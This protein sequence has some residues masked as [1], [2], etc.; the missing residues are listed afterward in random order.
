[1]AKAIGTFL[2]ALSAIWIVFAVLRILAGLAG[3]TRGTDIALGF[4]G[5]LIAVATF[6]LGTWLKSRQPGPPVTQRVQSAKSAWWRADY[7]FRLS[8]FLGVVWAVGCYLW[9]DDYDRNLGLVFWPPIGLLLA[10]LGYRKFVVGS[11]AGQQNRVEPVHPKEDSVSDTTVA[12]QSNAASQRE[13]LIAS[14][15][16]KDRERSMNDLINKMK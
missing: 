9:Q 14:Q 4:V 5:L 7:G 16:S 1:M 8:V 11:P 6:K 15:T 10:Y 2:R 3:V 13:T 12:K